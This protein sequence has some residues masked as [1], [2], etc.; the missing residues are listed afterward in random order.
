MNKIEI[1]TT[2][3]KLDQFLKWAA[4][5]DNGA[6]A[7]SMILDG[8]VKVNSKVC[9]SRGKKIDK[10]DKVEIEGLGLFEVC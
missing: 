3:I 9:T 7:K 1:N 2:N 6:M 10:G 8:L 4:I 5:A